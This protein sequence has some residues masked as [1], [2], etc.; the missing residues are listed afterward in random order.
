MPALPLPAFA[1]PVMASLA[2]GSRCRLSATSSRHALAS[3][4]TRIGRCVSRSKLTVHRFCALG[5]GGGGGGGG[6][7]GAM[8]DTLVRPDAVPP[9]SSETLQV[10]VMVPAPAPTVESVALEVVPLME[11]PDAL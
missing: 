11:P 4:S 2:L 1:L 5:A 6:A 9:L 8:T 7:G 3:L 10:T